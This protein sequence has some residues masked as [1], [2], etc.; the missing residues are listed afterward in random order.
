MLIPVQYTLDLDLKTVI[1]Q[2]NTG[3]VHDMQCNRSWIGVATC[4]GMSRIPKGIA[5]HSTLD[6]SSWYFLAINS[7]SGL[8][9]SVN[10][11]AS[12]TMPSLPIR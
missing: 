3:T 9:A 2:V 1:P 11:S 6:D 8:D 10:I 12:I 4:S 7:A 5:A